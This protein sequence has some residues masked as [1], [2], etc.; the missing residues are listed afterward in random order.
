MK[1]LSILLFYTLT[2]VGL[3]DRLRGPVEEVRPESRLLQNYYYYSTSNPVILGK[4]NHM[5]AFANPLKGLLTSPQWTGGNT[6]NDVPS[7]LEFHYIGFDSVMKGNNQFDWRL[8]DKTLSD[9]A[10][11]NNHV[12]WRITCHHP[13]EP[14]R[15]PQYLLNSVQLVPIEDG[16]ASPQYNDPILL[17]AF[18]QFIAAFGRRYDGHKSIGFIQLGLLGLW[19]EWHTHPDDGLISQAT[20]NKV[21][22]W[23]AAAFKTT[24]LQCRVPLPSAIAAGMGLHD[25]SFAYSTLGK[26]DW[27]F[28]PEVESTQQTS[29]WKKGAMGGETRPEIQSSVFDPSYQPG[30][31]EYKQ[32]FNTCVD[33]THATYML[34]HWV[35]TG[36]MSGATVSNALKAHARMGYNF[37]VTNVG[38][39]SLSDGFVT[40]DVTVTQTGVAPFYYPLGLALKCPGMTA[41]LPGVDSL[42]ETGSSKVFSFNNIPAESACLGNIELVLESSF[43]NAG[44]PVRFA[45][46][47]DGTVTLKIPVPGS[48]GSA[49][50]QDEAKPSRP[51]NIFQS[52]FK[53]RNRGQ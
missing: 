30:S 38:A 37:Q 24:Q 1:L 45:Q 29:F 40:V 9:A 28:W 3:S 17:E 2:H 12:I 16:S 14:L 51:C 32:D 47:N 34:H 5:A 43:V 33:V 36:E 41:T 39:A 4:A 42:I 13:D 18:R 50:S 46:G 23:Y 22:S 26:I 35:F 31:D 53:R 19:G 52:L 21:V 10:S 7:S 44:R 48:G 11:R 27:F 15:L 25:D 8:L 49:T 20:M 6:R